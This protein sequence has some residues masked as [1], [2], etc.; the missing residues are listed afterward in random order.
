[1]SMYP[2]AAC[3]VGFALL[4]AVALLRQVLGEDGVVDLVLDGPV[5]GF[6]LWSN[7]S[8]TVFAAVN[9]SGWPASA[10]E[11]DL[12]F[13]ID[14][15]ATPDA[16][17]SN[18][19]CND[20]FLTTMDGRQ[21]TVPY[22]ELEP[23][24]L[25]GGCSLLVIPGAGGQPKSFEGY[26]SLFL[27]LR[28]FVAP[29]DIAPIIE[30]TSWRW[31]FIIESTES[32]IASINV[33]VLDGVT[34]GLRQEKNTSITWES[35]LALYQ[36]GSFEELKLVPLYQTGMILYAR[37]ALRVPSNVFLELQNVT[38]ST[39]ETPNDASA[40]AFDLTVDA[41][42]L[43]TADELSQVD[44]GVELPF[45]PRCYLHVQSGISPT[46]GTRRLAAGGAVQSVPE[47]EETTLQA[48]GL[49]MAAPAEVD[50]AV[51]LTGFHAR[52]FRNAALE[53]GLRTV[54]QGAVAKAIHAFDPLS[55]VNVELQ[56]GSRRL[57][58]ATPIVMLAT[59]G[60][61]SQEAAEELRT[62]LKETPVELRDAVQ[63]A[64]RVMPNF[65]LISDGTPIDTTVVD[66][67]VSSTAPGLPPPP[68]PPADVQVAGELPSSSASVKV[69]VAAL[70]G[71]FALGTALGMLLHCQAARCR[72]AGK[73]AA[74]EDELPLSPKET[75]PG[76]TWATS[77]K[78]ADC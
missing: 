45:C 51:Q 34:G 27:I 75:C 3:R 14:V 12:E 43:S 70:V 23:W 25:P 78:L 31:P 77:E 32:T 46:P 16:L 24:A 37:Q 13:K 8:G 69:R 66:V 56:P 52:I 54:L 10:K 9:T 62:R 7:E 49:T 2:A 72:P 64:V 71:V 22:E 26:L 57:Q 65:E 55:I 41:Q 76:S 4:A 5:P 21:A 60:V 48:I 17:T 35:T 73:K 67:L 36:D 15:K 42:V 44:F 38:L 63:I 58:S 39:S 1:M 47:G 6:A 11:G 30:V 18:S 61:G 50:M 19:G 28:P 29:P 33:G 20:D 53:E 74:A 68:A 59:I 40:T